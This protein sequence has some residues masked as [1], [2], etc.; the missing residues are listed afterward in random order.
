[1]AE[2]KRIGSFQSF[3]EM[4]AQKQAA[5]L[6][7]ETASKREALKAK[8]AAI[9]DELDVNDLNVETIEEGNA[10][11]FAAAK[12]RQEGKDEFEFNGKKYKVTLKADTGLKESEEVIEE[13]V[14][15]TEESVN[16]NKY[17]NAG[18]LGYNDQFLDR[19]KSLAKTISTELGLKSEFV[20]PWVGFDYI[21]MYAIGPGNVGGTILSGALDGSHTYDD[22]KAAAAKYLK[23][24]KV[25]INEA[26][27]TEEY[28][29]EAIIVTGK[30]DA[31]RVM[32]AYQ[33]FFNAYPALDTT[34]NH[35]GTVKELYRLA[36]EDANFSRE[37]N[38]TVN[39]MKGRLFPIEVKVADLNNTTLKVSTSKLQSLIQNHA[40]AISGAAKWSGLAI[41]EGTALF[42]D[43]IKQTK[44]AE[45]L[46]AAFNKAFESV[47]ILEARIAEGNAFGTARL[48]AIE[49][50]ED[51]FEF[52]GK[53]YKVTKV[54]AED[55]ELADELANESE[56]NGENTNPEG[57]PSPAGD[58][59]D[60][61]ESPE[62]AEVEVME[63]S[64]VNEGAK[65]EQ[66][67]MELYT[68]VAG[69]DGA[70]SEDELA[71]AD[72]DT[73]M[74]IVTA[75]GHKGSKAKKIADEF[76]KIATLESVLFEA[77]VEMDALDPDNKDFLKF[78]KK[79]KVKIVRKEM[80]GPGGNTPVITMQGKRKDLENILADC[81]YGWCDEDLAEY[82]EEAV[83]YEAAGDFAGWIAIDHKGTRLEIKAD[84]AKDL[85][86][87][88]KLAIAKLR[89]PKS[90]EGLLA[91]APAVEES[92][93]VN[94]GLHPKLK[95]AQKA[96]KKGETVYG[97][98]IRFPGRFKIV[99]LGDMLATV[100]Y[101]DGT[102]PME[103]AAMNIRIDSLQFESVEVNEAEVKSAEDFKEYAFSV[104]QKAFGE[105]FDEAKAQEVV[106]GLV[107]KYG[108]DYGAMV[109]ALQSSLAEA[110]EVTEKKADGT[111]SDDEDERREALMAEVESAMDQLLSK[112][113][114]DAEDIGG[115]FRSPG[116]M[117]DAKKIMDTKLKRFK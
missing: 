103:M 35:I 51:E 81:D 15:E 47:E 27:E 105:D 9:V 14:E 90:K 28:I 37:G 82:I 19:R 78:L 97:E 4:R 40:N 44:Y 53:T 43:S 71:K 7:E 17:A 87:A 69:P 45:G 42:L 116:I 5:Q 64:T 73:Y 16:E 79:N 12:A 36:M 1:M 68:Q 110:V 89:V 38:A 98:N 22:L 95:K 34:L 76:R 77:T 50:G 86:A 113:K 46:L 58:S 60:V 20:G 13:A 74:E 31:Q 108:E 93:E 54:D 25:K 32:K 21:D 91:I 65:E 107:S 56:I 18:K 57:Y 99:E 48:K 63:E 52:Q 83:V 88:K 85:W 106:D 70:Y 66:E 100:D 8:F 111:I 26:E 115:S 96:I 23:G 94:E 109:G 6:A 112:I 101:E 29:S 72:M 24:K 67:A 11:I 59:D 104:L 80:Q 117:Y 75:A 30:R 33:G 39:Q 62:Q 84:E 41:V 114:A 3:S 92:V 10:F 55:K 49:A 102:K 61:E 2:L